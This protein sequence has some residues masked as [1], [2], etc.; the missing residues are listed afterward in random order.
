MRLKNNLS[1]NDQQFVQFKKKVVPS[2]KNIITLQMQTIRR[3]TKQINAKNGSN[4]TKPNGNFNVLI[5]FSTNETRDTDTV[6]IRKT[7]WTFGKTCSRRTAN[8][9]KWTCP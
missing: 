4:T 5:N 7:L 9:T 1:I 2:D 8:S 3:P 6:T